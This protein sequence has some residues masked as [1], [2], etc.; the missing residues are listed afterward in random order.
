MDR[1]KEVGGNFIDTAD[2]YGTS[3]V[4]VGRYVFANAPLGCPAQGSYSSSL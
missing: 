4:V 2:V 1:Y 3:E